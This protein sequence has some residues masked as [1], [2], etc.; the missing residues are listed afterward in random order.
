MQALRMICGSPN[1][2]WTPKLRN[3]IIDDTN[4]FTYLMNITENAAK[5]TLRKCARRRIYVYIAFSS[6]RKRIT[7]PDLYYYT[8]LGLSLSVAPT[9]DSISAFQN[10]NCRQ[11]VYT[12]NFT[13][14]TFIITQHFVDSLFVPTGNAIR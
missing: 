13:P 7:C 8:V 2:L 3:H 14:F 12:N 4:S 1:E 6:F 9:F 11:V 10:L 5:Q